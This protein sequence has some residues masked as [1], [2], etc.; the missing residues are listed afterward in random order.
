MKTIEIRV[1]H[2]VLGPALLLVLYLFMP[3][4]LLQVVLLFLLVT[5]LLALLV[6]WLESRSYRVTRP[7]TIVYTHARERF[8][9]RLDLVSRAVIPMGSVLCLDNE[10]N[11]ATDRSP[12]VLMT[13]GPGE[14]ITVTYEASGA[15]RGEHTLG[16]VELSGCDP[17]GYFPWV[18]LVDSRLRVIIYPQI[19]RVQ[20]AEARG[21]PAGNLSVSNRL[22]ED[23]TQFRSVREYT[24]G[25]ELKRINWKVTARVGKLYATEYVPAIYFPVMIAV[26]LVADSYPVSGRASI[27]ERAIETAASLVFFYVRTKQDIG[28]VTTGRLPDDDSEAG[29]THSPI[30]AGYAHA[31]SLLEILSRVKANAYRADFSILLEGEALPARA[32]L[33][34]VTP[35]PNDRLRGVLAALRRRGVRATA[36]VAGSHAVERDRLTIAGVESVPVIGREDELVRE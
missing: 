27:I 5:R 23:L 20:H 21:L 33:I 22:Y 8:S 11:F 28:M 14:R 4:R 2:D 30:Q 35:P 18:Q 29:G 15:E 17:L 3:F 1:L 10:G 36:F 32:R 24:P 31:V 34:V 9:V 6:A 26:D 19:R 7:D 12:G 25:D 13:P 16:P